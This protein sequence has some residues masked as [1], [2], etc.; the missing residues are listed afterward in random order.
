MGNSSR[1][2]DKEGES[3]TLKFKWSL[4]SWA[5]HYGVCLD[6]ITLAL[7]WDLSCDGL[8]FLLKYTLN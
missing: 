8:Y 4:L 6:M 1:E 7:I 3:V 5:P 2:P